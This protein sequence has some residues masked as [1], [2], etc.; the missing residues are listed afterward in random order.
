M[1]TAIVHVIGVEAA[2]IQLHTAGGRH[3]QIFD[4]L[5]GRIWIDIA[6]NRLNG[7]L[8]QIVGIAGI[9]ADTL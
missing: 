4:A 8:Q 2:V 9:S 7:E 3:I 6:Q 5:Y 1:P